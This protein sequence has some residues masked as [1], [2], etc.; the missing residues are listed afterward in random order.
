MFWTYHRVDPTARGQLALVSLALDA[1][2]LRRRNDAMAAHRSQWDRHVGTAG[3]AGTDPV[4]TPDLLD[5][6]Q[7]PLE[8][9]VVAS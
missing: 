6:L 8:H 4:L 1:T 2:E 7:T 5:L 9:Y 3:T